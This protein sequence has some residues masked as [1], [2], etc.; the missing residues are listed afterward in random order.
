MKL[1]MLCNVS[2]VLVLF[3][4]MAGGGGGSQY[5]VRKLSSGRSVKVIGV[6]Q[7]NFPDS[8]PAL[9]LKYETDIKISDRVALRKEAD[10]IWTDFRGD[11][12][13]AMVSSAILSANAPQQGAI[14]QKS[15]GYNFVFQKQSD[16]TWRCNE[17]H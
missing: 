1:P 15:E 17:D 5:Q 10:E 16:G 4:C 13:R 8:G 11:V 14:I 7:M 12:E 6:G 3:G 2:I 9:M